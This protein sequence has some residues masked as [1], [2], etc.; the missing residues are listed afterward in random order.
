MLP[1]VHKLFFFKEK[2]FFFLMNTKW[3]IVLHSFWLLGSVSYA[4]YLKGIRIRLRRI[5]F[6]F[7]I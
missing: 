6:F 3:M 7:F 1:P 2:D 4:L 5:G